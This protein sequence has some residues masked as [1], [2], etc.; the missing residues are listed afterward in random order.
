MTGLGELNVG[1]F[2]ATMDDVVKW[3]DLPTSGHPTTEQTSPYLEM[4][5]AMTITRFGSIFPRCEYCGF[6]PSG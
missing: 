4:Y 1:D 2:L 5:V 3:Q 6:A